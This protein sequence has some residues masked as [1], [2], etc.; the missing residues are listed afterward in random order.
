MNFKLLTALSLFADHM[1]A[2]RLLP[3]G[4]QPQRNDSVASTSSEGFKLKRFSFADIPKTLFYRKSYLMKEYNYPV[5]GSMKALAA[6]P[7]YTIHIWRGETWKHHSHLAFFSTPDSVSLNDGEKLKLIQSHLDSDL[8]HKLCILTKSKVSNFNYEGVKD[9]VH[10]MIAAKTVNEKDSVSK[11]KKS[12]LGLPD[13]KN[14]FSFDIYAW[15]TEY[16]C[17]LYNIGVPDAYFPSKPVQAKTDIFS[18]SSISDNVTYSVQV[19]KT[20][21]DDKDALVMQ[22]N[23]GKS[24]LNSKSENLNLL[25]IHPKYNSISD[26][27]EEFK[28]FQAHPFEFSNVNGK[29][30]VD[31]KVKDLSQAIGLST[32]ILFLYGKQGMAALRTQT[33]AGD[34]DFKD[35]FNLF[36]ESHSVTFVIWKENKA[37]QNISR[38]SSASTDSESSIKSIEL[39]EKLSGKKQPVNTVVSYDEDSDDDVADFKRHRNNDA[40]S[41]DETPSVQIDYDSDDENFIQ[42]N[43]SK[44]SDDEA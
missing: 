14:Q 16:D 10:S 15:E 34:K 25:P 2:A 32:G 31:G 3:G 27:T 23:A 21:V 38:S 24:D 39:G 36:P 5:F 41:D 42:L 6:V 43:D 11:T 29:I 18:H 8:K 33:F 26:L 9:F 13:L 40:D 4:E 20:Q 12:K 35:F 7:A 44:D 1:Q 19:S 17:A 22:V 37:L 28:N 30:F